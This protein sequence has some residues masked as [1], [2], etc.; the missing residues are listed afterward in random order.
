MLMLNVTF[1]LILEEVVFFIGGN[2]FSKERATWP[3]NYFLTY[4]TFFI[5]KFYI[6]LL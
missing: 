5:Q 3:V 2:V 6:F 1:S 4:R